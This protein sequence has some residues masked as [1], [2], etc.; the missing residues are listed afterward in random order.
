M[1][2]P[3]CRSPPRTPPASGYCFGAGSSRLCCITWGPCIPGCTGSISS[4]RTGG[5]RCS[6]LFAFVCA[7]VQKTSDASKF[8][9]TA[10][11]AVQRMLNYLTVPLRS[12]SPQ[13]MPQGLCISSLAYLTASHEASSR[14]LGAPA[15]GPPHSGLPSLCDRGPGSGGGFRHE[16]ST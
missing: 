9:Y 15:D 4:Q 7:S 11:Q 12:P 10:A 2:P 6:C 8:R 13:L 14:C 3:A 1:Q 16:S 5:R